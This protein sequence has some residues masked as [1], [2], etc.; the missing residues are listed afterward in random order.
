MVGVALAACGSTRDEEDIER[1]A[2]C[3]TQEPVRLLEVE[4][5]DGFA[6]AQ[7]GTAVVGERR[8]AVWYDES[9]RDGDPPFGAYVLD[10]CGGGVSQLSEHEFP[11]VV[12]E[13]AFVCDPRDGSIR[14]F[15]LASVE[16]GEVLASG[17][18]C[19]PLR[20]Q[21]DTLLLR[22]WDEDAYGLLRPEGVELLDYPLD[23]VE[24]ES[25]TRP[26]GPYLGRL[27]PHGSSRENE[28]HRVMTWHGFRQIDLQTSEVFE[29]PDG[30]VA[31]FGSRDG[32]D[33]LLVFGADEAGETRS[34]EID[35]LGDE[36]RPGPTFSG[37]VDFF[38]SYDFGGGVVTET[39]VFLA[40]ERVS[41]PLPGPSPVGGDLVRVSETL[42]A[43]IF[44]DES[45]RAEVA[46]WES[47]SNE[48]WRVIDLPPGRLCGGLGFNKTEAAF[49]GRFST[50]DDCVGEEFWTVPLDGST[51]IFVTDVGNNLTIGR[52]A[53]G[54]EFLLRAPSG[55]GRGDLEQL[56]IETGSV[57]T[58]A[59]DIDGLASAPTPALPRIPVGEGDAVEYYVRD[60]AQAGLW[61]SGLP[62]EF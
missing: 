17:Y 3:G 50:D 23:P 2:V 41:L 27:S 18:D 61:I 48:G 11:L 40:Q 7:W 14:R 16:A 58:L 10:A 8:I 33:I 22:N 59:R 34:V 45:G 15:D 42:F 35:T 56:H 32:E 24:S 43:S 44:R 36:P 62:A 52:F 30:V 46:V 38:F 25:N 60:G 13:E 54:D 53:L 57:A 19:S 9:A 4:V 6:G 21:G 47:D 12:G 20:R 55:R 29:L 39:S 5:S 26:L 31:G 1:L 37:P 51:P 28:Q 49:E